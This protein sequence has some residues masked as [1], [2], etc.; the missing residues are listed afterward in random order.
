MD[1]SNKS[2]ALLLVAAIIVSLGGT[3]ISLNKLGSEGFS[4]MA[5]SSGDV[6]L[7]ITSSVSCS[8]SGDI[9]FGAAAANPSDEYNLS[10]GRAHTG[11]WTIDCTSG[12]TCSGIQIN[13][14]GTE[15]LLVNFSSSVTGSSWSGL[16]ANREATWFRY[17]AENGTTTGT[18]DGCTGTLTNTETNVALSNNAVCTVLSYVEDA[19]VVTLEFNV[20]V[21]EATPSGSKSALITIECVQA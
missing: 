8:A 2:L 4:G 19:S 13:N 7:S 17:N 11:T 18:Q 5:Y 10:S 12:N 16:G 1:M 3:M 6:N 15:N 9:N 14:T 21:D 20:T